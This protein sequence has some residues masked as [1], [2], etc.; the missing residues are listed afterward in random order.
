MVKLRDP[1]TGRF[2][3]DSNAHICPDCGSKKS[4]NAKVCVK[5]IGKYRKKPSNYTLRKC[6]HCGNEFLAHIGDI[7]RGN[8]IYCCRQ[9]YFDDHPPRP[10][11]RTQQEVT[12]SKCGKKILRFKS[13]IKKN[14]R[15]IFFCSHKCCQEYNT[16][17]NRW[18]YIHDQ[19]LRKENRHISDNIYWRDLIFI[20]DN[21]T[22]QICGQ[23]GGKLNAHH[24]RPWRTYPELRFDTTNGITVCIQCHKKMHKN[25]EEYINTL[26]NIIKQK[27][28]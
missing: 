8:G 17:R 5:C 1:V 27:E 10:N 26:E 12:C 25:E 11:A 15:N 13:E 2:L 16:G 23:R 6:K 19:S 18:N 28:G 4:S 21:Y 22:C 3:F 20:R 24:I 7:S 14:I 9:C